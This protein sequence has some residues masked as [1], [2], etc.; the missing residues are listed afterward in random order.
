MT[1]MSASKRYLPACL[2]GLV[3]ASVCQANAGPQ[4]LLDPYA[5]IQAP[6]KLHSAGEKKKKGKFGLPSMTKTP[7]I[8]KTQSPAAQDT[9]NTTYVTAPGGGT[10]KA[11]KKAL[12]PTATST[13]IQETASAPKKE[14]GGVMGGIKGIGDSCT[15]TMKAA[16]SGAVTATKAS[17]TV[18]VSGSKKVG[19][20][21]ANGAKAS[22]GVLV[23]GAAFVGNGFKS[24][25]N[26]LKESTGKIAKISLPNPLAGKKNGESLNKQSA[27]AIKNKEQKQD[28][29]N[30]SHALD[31]NQSSVA[32]QPAAQ[33]TKEIAAA[34][35]KA[36]KLAGLT[37]LPQN[38]TKSISKLNPFN[39]GKKNVQQ[40]QPIAGKKNEPTI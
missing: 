31:F 34:P 1:L 17:A 18:V 36:S 20:G 6:D 19:S 14:Q 30:P 4:S 9:N 28:D 16:T 21:I 5:N 3:I 12:T 39:F 38:M 15:K 8:K 33:T 22:G 40:Q 13:V 29:L 37:H 32:T 26:K 27:I 7:N 2:T 25:G 24:T 10:G 11:V 23:K 35:A